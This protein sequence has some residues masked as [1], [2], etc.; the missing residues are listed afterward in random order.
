[1]G[2]REAIERFGPSVA[3]GSKPFHA[4]YGSDDELLEFQD[5][6][7]ALVLEVTS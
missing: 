3:T 1:M 4:M 7:L 5:A 6:L 2:E